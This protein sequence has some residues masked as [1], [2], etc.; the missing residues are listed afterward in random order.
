[1]IEDL[2]A[3]AIERELDRL[4]AGVGR[5]LS[6]AA[7]TGST[8]DD[9]RRAAEAGAPHGAAFIADAQSSGRGR[10]GH[11]W[12]SP[13]GQNLYISVVLRPRIPAERVAPIALV[14]GLAVATTVERRLGD[15]PLLGIKWP[16]DVLARGRKLGGVLV[17]GRLRGAEVG[18]LV[19][20]VGVNVRTQSFPDAIAARATSLFLLGCRD[21]DRAT[22]A[23][24]LIAA[25]GEAAA[26]FEREHLAP[27]AADLA[28]RDALRGA[29][30]DVSDQRG[31]AEGIDEEGRLLVRSDDGVLH[32]IAAGEV[33]LSEGG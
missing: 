2:G 1:M 14:V 24:Q 13:P 7:L 10:G 26:V 27:F 30:V 9:A 31:V 29:R 6:V 32:R 15:E 33:T 25:I 5:P 23:A 18:S 11:T 19:V 17:E 22:L 21:L 16:N 4:G 20:G 28:R 12:H 8:N 3:A